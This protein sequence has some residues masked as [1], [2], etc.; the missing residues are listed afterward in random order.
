MRLHKFKLKYGGWATINLDDVVTVSWDDYTKI[1][2]RS[3]HRF[4]VGDV[5]YDDVV[6]IWQEGGQL[7]LADKKE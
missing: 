7:G 2:L 5:N 6:R 1:Y 3:G 4:G